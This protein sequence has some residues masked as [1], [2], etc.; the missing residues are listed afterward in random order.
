MAKAGIQIL[1]LT[2]LEFEANLGILDQEKKAP[3]PIRVAPRWVCWSRF[4]RSSPG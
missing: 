3:Q 4:R 2:G 1:T